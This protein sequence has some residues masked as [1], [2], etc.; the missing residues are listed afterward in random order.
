LSGKPGVAEMHLTITALKINGLSGIN[1][2]INIGGTNLAF[3][4]GILTSYG[5]GVRSD[6]DGESTLSPKR[7]RQP[8]CFSDVRSRIVAASTKGTTTSEMAPITITLMILT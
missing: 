6:G 8:V 7:R 3:T 1:D 4:H 2:T 5:C